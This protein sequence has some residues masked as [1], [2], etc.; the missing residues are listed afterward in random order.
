MTRPENLNLIE[1]THGFDLV[2]P[3]GTVPQMK[4]I[5]K[6]QMAIMKKLHEVGC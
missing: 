5:D 1:P 4:L 6:M 2:P 3:E